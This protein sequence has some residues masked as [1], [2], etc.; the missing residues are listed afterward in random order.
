MS[1]PFENS[2]PAD[3]THFSAPLAGPYHLWRM[4]KQR[5][6]ARMLESVGKPV[7]EALTR[8]ISSTLTRT[9]RSLV[10]PVRQ[11]VWRHRRN[12]S[13][14]ETVVYETPAELRYAC[15]DNDH[16]ENHNLQWAQGKAG[17]DRVH[18]VVS[19]DHGWLFVGIYDGFNGPDAPDFLMSNLY[20]E[21][22]KQLRGL[23]WDR[24][25][26]AG[27]DM[28]T[29]HGDASL[30]L[31]SK[32]NNSQRCN[33]ENDDDGNEQGIRNSCKT[34][35]GDVAMHN[36]F[37]ENL[38]QQRLISVD[39]HDDGSPN[40]DAHDDVNPNGDHL[41]PH[42]F[43]QAVSDRRSDGCDGNSMKDDPS[44]LT[45]LKCRNSDSTISKGIP[46]PHGL[47]G[48]NTLFLGHMQH[49]QKK[50][51]KKKICLA[52]QDKEPPSPDVDHRSN[53]SHET[54]FVKKVSTDHSAVL[55]ALENA[56]DSTERSY[57]QMAEH[58]MKEMPEL[59]L[60]GSCVLVMLMKGADVYVMNVGDSRAIL[61][62]VKHNQDDDMPKCRKI[63]KCS[64][65][66]STYDLERIGG[67]E[68]QVRQEPER[69]REDSAAGSHTFECPHA[70]MSTK[71]PPISMLLSALQLSSDH[72]TNIKEVRSTSTTQTSRFV[73]RLLY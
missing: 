53:T 17:E 66:P 62:Q 46:S 64:N 19:E 35:N 48:E 51:K 24:K 23:L 31:H 60:M 32:S 42:K 71:P 28:P 37:W 6:F 10:A 69:I 47:H 30:L 43:P 2:I 12:G 49:I 52:A 14:G 34:V 67:R 5:K 8:T 70:C 26:P 33:H 61:A 15:R 9:R 56:L 44:V 3:Q 18:V 68:S 22:Y 29:T 39:C 73:E 38:H 1:G 36:S 63:S 27:I 20:R 58:S 16:N 59:A 13:K 4:R 41:D 72:S 65:V 54:W 11:F 40:L 7:R 45:C 25:E 55:K 57:L 21:V 50:K